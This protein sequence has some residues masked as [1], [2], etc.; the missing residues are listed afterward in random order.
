[1]EEKE[2]SKIDVSVRNNG[3]VIYPT[4]FYGSFIGEI[5]IKEMGKENKEKTMEIIFNQP[6]FKNIALKRYHLRYLFSKIIIKFNIRFLC[7]SWI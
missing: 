5:T 2:D 7:F 1:M 4:S 3:R 6:L